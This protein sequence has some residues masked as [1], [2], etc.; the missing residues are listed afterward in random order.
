MKFLGHP[1]STALHE[2]IDE[3]EGK[4]LEI[5]D[6]KDTNFFVT[7]MDVCRNHLHDRN[8]AERINNLLHFKNNYNL[9]GDSYKESVYQYVETEK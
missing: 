8:L 1:P 3:I 4:E 5:H 2:I 6:T 7:A 9:I